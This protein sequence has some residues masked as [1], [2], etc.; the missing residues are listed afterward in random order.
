MSFFNQLLLGTPTEK[1]GRDEKKL[2]DFKAC[3]CSLF[4]LS[5]LKV[6]FSLY[7]KDYVVTGGEFIVEKLRN[8]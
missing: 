2:D 7:L 8:L 6:A 5:F 3:G 4:S 1:K